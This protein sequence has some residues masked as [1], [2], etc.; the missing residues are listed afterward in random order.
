M[1][2]ISEFLTPTGFIIL[3]IGDIASYIERRYGHHIVAPEQGIYIYGQKKPTLKNGVRYIIKSVKDPQEQQKI[4]QDINDP[5]LNENYKILDESGNE[6]ISSAIL[7]NKQQLLS[8]YPSFPV[9]GMEIAKLC[10]EYYVSKR[11]IFTNNSHY[12]INSIDKKFLLNAPEELAQIIIDDIVFES[13]YQQ[14][15]QF[16]DKDVNHVYFFKLTGLTD[17]IIEK[18]ID[19]RAYQWHLMNSTHENNSI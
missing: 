12:L 11:N 10:I 4:L 17:L 14:V 15:N 7:K 13:V 6:V 2:S 3:N 18:T 9:V 8:S 5:A 1:S 19:W 16:I